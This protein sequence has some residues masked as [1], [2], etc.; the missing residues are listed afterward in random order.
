MQPDVVIANSFARARYALFELIAI[1]AKTPQWPQNYPRYPL[2]DVILSLNDALTLSAYCHSPFLPVF[3]C[4]REGAE[5]FVPNHRLLP[6]I[7]LRLPARVGV[8][9]ILPT[10]APNQTP[11]K[12]VDSD[13][14]ELRSRLRLRSPA[15]RYA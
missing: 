10:P 9:Q 15:Y 13:R 7:N 5:P 2:S 4:F 6:A 1:V 12:T 3:Q 14:I 8:G 11:A